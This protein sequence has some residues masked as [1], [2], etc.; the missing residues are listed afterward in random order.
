MLTPCWLK[1]P[2]LIR[3]LVPVSFS[4]SLS[5]FLADSLERGGPLSSLSRPGF[6]APLERVRCAFTHLRG[7]RVPTCSSASPKNGFIGFPR[8]QGNQPLSLSYFL[9]VDSG[10][11]GSGPLKGQHCGCP[12]FT[13]I[14]SKFFTHVP[15]SI[16]TGDVSCQSHYLLVRKFRSSSRC[17]DESCFPS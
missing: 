14:D 2:L 7:R 12:Y 8:N 11:P 13:I 4:P 15:H 17:G 6:S 10:P 3:A 16:K 5:L 9:I 1:T